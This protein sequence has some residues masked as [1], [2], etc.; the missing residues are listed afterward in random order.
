MQIVRTINVLTLTALLILTGCFGLNPPAEG[1]ETTNTVVNNPPTVF[2]SE[3]LNEL[4][5][6]RGAE[7]TYS[8]FTGDLRGFEVMLYHAAVDVDGDALTMGWDLDLDGQIDVNT[9]EQAGFTTL[10]LPLSMLNELSAFDYDDH[11]HGVLAFIAIDE[12]GLA[13]TAITEVFMWDP[14]GGEDD[15][16]TD[17]NLALYA[18]SGEDAQGQPSTGTDD[19]LIMLTMDQGGDINW[20]SVSV[21]LSIDGGSPVFC[22]NPG[23]DGGV[24]VLVDNGRDTNDQFWSVGDTVTIVETGTDLCSDTCSIDVTITDTREGKVIDTTNGVPAE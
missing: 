23:G 16:N 6:E 22:D 1:A 5:Q 14:E 15:D 17:G 11:Y 4:V 3:S 8:R 2:I 24:C 18:F 9:T 20:A 10:E 12:H 7:P 21:K 13:D 19:N